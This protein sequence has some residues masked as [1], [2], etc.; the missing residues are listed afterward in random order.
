MHVDPDEFTTHDEIS[1]ILQIVVRRLCDG[2]CL[3][4]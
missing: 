3:W 1:T 4:D 2:M